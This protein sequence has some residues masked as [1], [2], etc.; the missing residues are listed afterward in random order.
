[1]LRLLIAVLLAAFSLSACLPVAFVAGATAGGAVVSDQRSLKT[2]IQDRDIA[3]TALNRLNADAEIYQ[4]TH[5]VIASYNKIV[6][7]AGQAPNPE[8]K[9]KVYNI[10][11]TVPGIRRIYNEVTIEPPLSNVAIANDS[12]LTTKVKSSMLAEKGLQSTAIKVVT[13]NNTVYLMGIVTHKQGELAADVARQVGGVQ[14]V[15]KIFE[16]QQ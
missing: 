2:S 3:N 7:L 4:Q 12:W 11:Q 16:Y 10:V 15:V 9:Q 6:L 14:K 1:M 13:E 5:I 8:L